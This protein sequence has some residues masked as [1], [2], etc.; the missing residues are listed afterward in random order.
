[1]AAF[2]HGLYLEVRDP[3]RGPKAGGSC[4]TGDTAKN[5][6]PCPLTE[7]RGGAHGDSPRRQEKGASSSLS[8][9]SDPFPAVIQEEAA[10]L[11]TAAQ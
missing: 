9:I 7:G 4:T 10:L 3:A 6:R 1:M 5:T 11:Q 2:G 8:A